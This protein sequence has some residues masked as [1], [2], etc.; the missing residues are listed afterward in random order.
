[1]GLHYADPVG[2]RSHGGGSVRWR[3]RRGG[4]AVLLYLCAWSG[5]FADGDRRDGEVP[6]CDYEV[7]V[8]PFGPCCGCLG[9]PLT[10]GQGIND[11]GHI[12]GYYR[13]CADIDTW[14]FLWKGGDEIIT[15]EPPWEG[16]RSWAFDINSAGQIIGTIESPEIGWRAFLFDGKEFV[17]LGTL[18]GGNYSKATAINESGQITG[19]WGNSVTGDP[20]GVEAFVWEAGVMTGLGPILGAKQSSG[21]DINDH[22]WITGWMGESILSSAAFVW[23]GKD[24]IELEFPPGATDAKGNAINNHGDVA[25]RIVYTD[26]ETGDMTLEAALWTQGKLIKLGHLPG[27]TKCWSTDINDRGEVLGYCRFPATPSR[28]FLW[29]DGEMRE[30]KSLVKGEHVSLNLAWAIN[31]SGLITG[32]DIDSDAFVAAPLNPPRTDL[33][34]DC[35]TD[36][37]DLIILLAQWGQAGAAD[38]D[39]DGTTGLIDLLLLL[40]QWS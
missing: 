36:G 22:G 11:M 24:V 29:R 5:A 38:F 6:F 33:T 8:A 3:A 15:L 18:P 25:G 27:A 35:I 26:P 19:M 10:S 21:E 2:A 39:G 31:E 34:G 17:N 12:V 28:P 7:L 13:S 30:L 32:S 20:T 37:R 1:M 16:R 40:D 14:A 23:D 9:P 4:A